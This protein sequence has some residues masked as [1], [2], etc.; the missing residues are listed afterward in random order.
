MK[1]YSFLFFAMKNH[2]IIISILYL[3][4][5][6]KKEVMEG[7]RRNTGREEKS[8]KR[9][10]EVVKDKGVNSGDRDKGKQSVSVGCEVSKRQTPH[11][12]M[13]HRGNTGLNTLELWLVDGLLLVALRPFRL[14]IFFSSMRFP[15]RG[16]NLQ[17]P[18]SCQ[19]QGLQKSARLWLLW[20]LPRVQF[21]HS[22]STWWRISM[23]S[24][25]W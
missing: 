1:W 6:L 11:T 17:R 5:Y 3:Q 23:N 25:E 18:V 13:M 2:P 22:N 10:S 12:L 4:V 14:Y 9:R 20:F 19:C 7:W 21:S 16:A 15:T 24:I 8:W